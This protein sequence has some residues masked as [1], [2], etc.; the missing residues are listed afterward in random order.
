[1]HDLLRWVQKGLTF[2]QVYC[3]LHFF[4]DLLIDWDERSLNRAI[5][6]LILR[7]C[8]GLGSLIM[9]LIRG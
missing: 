6:F 4:M 5:S 1:M 3:E 9:Y 8:V 2:L 7:I